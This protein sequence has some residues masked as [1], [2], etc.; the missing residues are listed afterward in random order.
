MKTFTIFILVTLYSSIG[1]ALGLADFV[2]GFLSTHSSESSDNL[3]VKPLVDTKRNASANKTWYCNRVQQ[4]AAANVFCN[5]NNG[6]AT[7]KFVDVNSGEDGD[8]TAI[9]DNSASGN[10]AQSSSNQ[11]AL[12]DQSTRNALAQRNG[13]FAVPIQPS[14]NVNLNVNQQQI[15]VQIKY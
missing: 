3:P 12:Q 6:S 11:G 1:Y 2:P 13:Q 7:V 5:K 14:K 9:I 15:Q 4:N 10:Y 8:K